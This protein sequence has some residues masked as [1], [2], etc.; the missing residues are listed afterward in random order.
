MMSPQPCFRGEFTSVSESG[1]GVMAGALKGTRFA[2]SR[3]KAN[4]AMSRGAIVAEPLYVLFAKYGH[5]DAHE[6]VRRLTLEAERGSRSVLE[7]VAQDAELRDYL[8][9]LSPEERRILERPED[10]RGLA[11]D[12]ARDGPSTARGRLKGV[13][14]E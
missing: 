14:P 2:R 12:V 4:L 9:K 6:V 8:T 1:A 5:P 7:V 10:Y 13:L 11:A 3:L